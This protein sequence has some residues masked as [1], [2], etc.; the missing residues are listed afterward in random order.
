ML[1]YASKG[2]PNLAKPGSTNQFVFPPVPHQQKIHPTERPTE[3]IEDI[4]QTFVR[5]DSQVLVPFLGSGKTLLAAH[6]SNMSAFGFELSE[7]YRDSF[8]IKVNEEVKD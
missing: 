4:L 7:I 2:N 8:I 1:F 6:R 3:L 5:P